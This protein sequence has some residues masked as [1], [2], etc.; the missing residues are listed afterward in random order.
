MRI[1]P[2]DDYWLNKLNVHLDH[3]EKQISLNK[4]QALE[5][6]AKKWD[7]R[8]CDLIAQEVGFDSEVHNDQID[9]VTGLVDTYPNESRQFIYLTEFAKRKR[10]EAVLNVAEEKLHPEKLQILELD[11]RKPSP[12]DILW[13]LVELFC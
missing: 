3:V 5:Q 1:M 12:K 7:G 9:F 4:E 13:L 2:D 11:R 10:K 6:L 8:I